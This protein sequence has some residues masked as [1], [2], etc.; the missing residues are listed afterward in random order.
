MATLTRSAGVKPSTTKPVTVT[1]APGRRDG[2]NEGYAA[3]LAEFPGLDLRS[4]ADDAWHGHGTFC[5]VLPLDMLLELRIAA[6]LRFWRA[7]GRRRPGDWR[8]DFPP[9]T[10]GHHVLTLRA[11]D[12]KLDS[13]SYR[14]IAEALLGFH[15]RKADWETDPRKNQIRRLVADGL[16]YMRGGYRDLLRYPVRLPQPSGRQNRK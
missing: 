3:D 12:G 5:V 16:H 15:G 11:L 13:A 7:L 10:R 14:Q 2:G 1:S 8:T 6:P 4:A 9:Q